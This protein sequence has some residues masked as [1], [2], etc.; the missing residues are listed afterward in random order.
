MSAFAPTNATC[1]TRSSNCAPICASFAL[2]ILSRP[3]S[4]PSSLDDS[5]HPPWPSLTRFERRIVK[6]SLKSPAFIQLLDL[7]LQLHRGVGG[8]LVR[9][10]GRDEGFECA[11]QP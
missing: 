3:R 11:G 2:A 5:I 1:V 10:L 9:E 4:V 6:T 7:D 8:E